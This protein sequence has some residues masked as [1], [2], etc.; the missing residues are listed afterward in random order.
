MKLNEITTNKKPKGGWLTGAEAKVWV[1]KSLDIYN[2]DKN[3]SGW[4]DPDG[5]TINED[6]S[7]RI[8]TNSWNGEFK[9]KIKKI[10][11][12]LDIKGGARV[13]QSLATFPKEVTQSLYLQKASISSLE[14]LPL[15]NELFIGDINIKHLNKIFPFIKGPLDALD[16]NEMRIDSLIG[17]SD[18]V[19]NP[20]K[21]LVI[22]KSVKQ[23]GLGLLLIPGLTNL[24]VYNHISGN[25][26]EAALDIIERYV[27]RPDDIFECQNELIEAGLEEYAQL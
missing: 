7:L 16:I 14:G 11:G 21:T 2:Q 9:V 8:L 6:V 23:G 27:G 12:Y 17:I 3:I 13:V 15:C 25:P 20:I 1:T 5:I 10:N 26:G 22:N 4:E 24:I 18:L 19:I